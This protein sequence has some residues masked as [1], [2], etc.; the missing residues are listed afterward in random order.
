LTELR[1]T[2]SQLHVQL[3][4]LSADAR[5]NVRCGGRTPDQILEEMVRREARY[6]GQYA[7]LLHEQAAVPDDGGPVSE[8][9]FERRRAETLALL[10][11]TNTPWPATLLDAAKQQIA[12]DRQAATELAECRRQVLESR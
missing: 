11:R 6:A 10:E 2:V 12:E 1:Y 8:E 9:T 4:D 7:R 3:G 5:S